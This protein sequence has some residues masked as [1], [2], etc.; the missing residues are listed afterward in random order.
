MAAWV[1]EEEKASEHQQRK[2]EADDADKVEIAPGVTVARL[3][4][5]RAASI[6]PTQGLS[7]QH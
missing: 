1:G 6:G 5:F 7:K 3:R 4:R 2:I